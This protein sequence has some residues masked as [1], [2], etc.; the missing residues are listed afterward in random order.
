MYCYLKKY[1]SIN[2]FC[3]NNESIIIQYINN[4]SNKTK[5]FSKIFVENNIEKF[6]IIIE[7][8]ILELK[9]EYRFKSNEKIVKVELILNK[10]VSEINMYK[11]FANCFNLISLNG[12]SKLIKA[13]IVNLS[14]MLYN[15]Y[16][17]SSIPDFKNWEL[18]KYNNY[19]MFYNCISLVFFPYK[20]N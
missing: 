5:L 4:I 7:D 16:S 20:K 15:C 14:K 11:M 17:L 6:K 1:N 18:K 10:N 19:L 9:K 2:E 12:I 8:K 13:R 3:Q